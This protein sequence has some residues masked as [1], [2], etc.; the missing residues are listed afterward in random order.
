MRSTGSTRSGAACGT[1]WCRNPQRARSPRPPRKQLK[2]YYD[3]HP[4]KF[5]QPEYR[6]LGI[7]AVTPETVK[8]QVAISED[9]LKAAYE[10]QKD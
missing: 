4:A 6:K 9:D 10:A 8:D 2:A 5:T 7:L 3:N 1:C